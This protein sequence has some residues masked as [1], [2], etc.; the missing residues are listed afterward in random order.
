[1]WNHLKN[2]EGNGKKQNGRAADGVQK[3][4]CADAGDHFR[5][6]DFN[7]LWQKPEKGKLK[8]RLVIPH[9]VPVFFTLN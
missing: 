5:P 2:G 4:V 9:P 6:E 8:D 3:S 1:M 7:G